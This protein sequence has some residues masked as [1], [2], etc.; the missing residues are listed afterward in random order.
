M[1]PGWA[2]SATSEPAKGSSTWCSSWTWCPGAWSVYRWH[3][4]SKRHSPPTRSAKRSQP[5]VGRCEVWCSTPTAARQYTAEA[6]A[7]LSKAVAS[8]N[9]WAEPGFVGTTPLPSRSFGTLKKNSSEPTTRTGTRPACQSVGGSKPGTIPAGSTPR[10]DISH[11]TNGRTTTTIPRPHK[12]SVQHTEGTPPYRASRGTLWELRL[13]GSPGRLV[14]ASG[15][16]ERV[17]WLR[18]LGM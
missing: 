16:G 14:T 12:P 17:G 10:S 9:P 8:A 6:T 5:G 1:C 15:Y 11:Q 2:I 18:D 7:W 13:L 3:H 4:T